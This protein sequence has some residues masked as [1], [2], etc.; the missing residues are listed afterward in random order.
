MRAVSRL[1]VVS[2]P[3]AAGARVRPTARLLVTDPLG[4]VLLFKF[5]HR[6]GALDGVSY[7]ATPGGGVEPGESVAQAA[8]RELREET[9]IEVDNVGAPV[10]E[11]RQIFKVDSG[12]HVCDEESYFHVQLAQATLVSR[13]GWTDYERNC[14]TAYRWWSALDLAQTVETIWPQDLSRLLARVVDQKG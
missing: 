13:A 12:E 9:G 14:M 7:W 3:E 4:R 2:S 11:R 6:G 5:V 1:C 10:A 8:R